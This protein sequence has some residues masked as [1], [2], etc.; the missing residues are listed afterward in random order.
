MGVSTESQQKFTFVV[1]TA[2]ESELV[3]LIDHA[4]LKLFTLQKHRE[5]YFFHSPNLWK[6]IPSS[7]PTLVEE[8][9]MIDKEE[10]EFLRLRIFAK[11]GE[12]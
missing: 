7:N 10:E 8:F 9:A 6:E 3:R 1:A 12:P 5:S 2:V 4:D 11:I